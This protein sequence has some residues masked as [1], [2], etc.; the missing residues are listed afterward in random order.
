MAL[1][2]NNRVKMEWEQSG[3]LQTGG[4]SRQVFLLATKAYKSSNPHYGT[5]DVFFKPGIAFLFITAA[6]TPDEDIWNRQDVIGM[7]KRDKPG[8]QFP[9]VYEECIA[10]GGGETGECAMA[11]LERF[12]LE[13]YKDDIEARLDDI[14]TYGEEYEVPNS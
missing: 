11:A 9:Y 14:A 10:L 7:M 12:G 4:K 8:D 5:L 6:E 2:V 1:V 3:W 13:A